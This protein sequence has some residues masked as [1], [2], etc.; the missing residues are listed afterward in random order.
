MSEELQLIVVEKLK[1]AELFTTPALLDT[2]LDGV[3][4]K[5]L[6]IVPDV[7]TAK[8]RKDIASVAYR[9]AQ[10]RVLL[11]NL[12]KEEVAKLKDLPKKIDAGRKTAREF[13]EKLQE[14]Y[15]QPLTAWEEVEKLRVLEEE[16]DRE[17]G[18]AFEAAAAKYDLIRREQEV[19]RKEAEFARIEEERRQKEESERLAK[20]QAEREERIRKEAE[21][22]AKREA[23]E[24]AARKIAEAKAAQERA[25]REAKEAAE[26]AEREK[27][28]AVEAAERKAREEADRVER[29]RV[30][31]EEAAKAE[32]ERLQQ[33]RIAKEEAERVAAEKKA[34][35]R[36]HQAKING[37]A[38]RCI[39]GIHGTTE[40][41]AAAIIE[42]IAA[43]SVPHVTIRY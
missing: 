19:A 42:A 6:S 12:G 27:R 8:G 25:E 5:V 14:E 24:A 33:E 22:R 39:K 7:S 38:V 31:K 23:E 26:R 30:A 16:I 28:E 43:G 13:L 15:R 10:S 34:A 20:E 21:E 3:R 35:N 40:E 2:L 41:Q 32:A 36:C 1:P 4:A 18:M 11:D 17:T 9:V 29:M 37:E